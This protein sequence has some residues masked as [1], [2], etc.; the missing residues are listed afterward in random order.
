MREIFK[1]GQLSIDADVFYN[2]NLE[3]SD[4][5]FYM[6]FYTTAQNGFSDYTNDELAEGAQVSKRT[7]ANILN[8][9]EALSII[10]IVHIGKVR[11][12]WRYEKWLQRKG[13]Q[14]R[15]LRAKELMTT[16][17]ESFI[18]MKMRSNQKIRNKRAYKDGLTMMLNLTDEPKHASV[19]EEYRK[20]AEQQIVKVFRGK[21]IHRENNIF[22]IDDIKYDESFGSYVVNTFNLDN[23]LVKF[24]T[25]TYDID[26]AY[27]LIENM[28]KTLEEVKNEND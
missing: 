13:K 27:M 22:V 19:L 9:L 11:Q 20:F 21:K 18:A 23:N 26:I 3:M 7:I 6:Y 10:K 4:K 2:E 5:L 28:L 17:K 16:L 24:N 8:R 15:I 25:K 12:I 14:E 1:P